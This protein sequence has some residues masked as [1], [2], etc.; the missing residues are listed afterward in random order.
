MD[1]QEGINGAK[2]GGCA[3]KVSN[4]KESMA[5]EAGCFIIDLS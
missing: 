1:V 4:Y 3:N 2:S 5:A